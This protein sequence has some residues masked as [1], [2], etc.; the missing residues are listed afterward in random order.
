MSVDVI[1]NKYNT[2]K[3]C[4]SKEKVRSTGKIYVFC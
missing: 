4:E 3:K 2:Q 1:R